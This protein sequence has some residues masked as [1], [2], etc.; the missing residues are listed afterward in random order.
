MLRNDPDLVF[1]RDND[2]KTPLH[3]AA[4]VGAKSIAELLLASWADVK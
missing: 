4:T 1:S 2:G 3:R